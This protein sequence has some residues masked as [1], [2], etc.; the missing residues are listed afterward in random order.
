M[1]NRHGSGYDATFGIVIAIGMI[2]LFCILI[3]SFIVPILAFI[4]IIVLMCLLVVFVPK[5]KKNKQEKAEA[6]EINRRFNEFCARVDKF[7]EELKKEK[8]TSQE[9]HIVNN[10]IYNSKFL[11]QIRERGENYFYENKVGDVR[12]TENTYGAV[13][14]GKQNYNTSITLNSGIIESAS[15]DCKYFNDTNKYCKHIYALLCKMENKL[16]NPNVGYNVKT[17]IENIKNEI[18]SQSEELT[19]I[20]RKCSDF[21]G[22]KQTEYVIFEIN[23]YNIF[24]NYYAD[25]LE[26]LE[27]K[28]KRSKSIK[29]LI[30]L[31]SE[32]VKIASLLFN[33]EKLFMKKDFDGINNIKEYNQVIEDYRKKEAKNRTNNNSNE[34]D[35][36]DEFFDNE[37]DDFIASEPKDDFSLLGMLANSMDSSKP[38]NKKNGTFIGGSKYSEEEMDFYDLCEEERDAVR[39]GNYTPIDFNKDT[40]LTDDDY[41]FEDDDMNQ[42]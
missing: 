30:D 42:Q 26:K 27:N 8:V 29:D 13:V 9:K 11:P 24:V 25:V 31:H 38:K 10:A 37:E 15:C 7:T 35:D 6:E 41:Y 12:K 39:S 21:L 3:A 2:V 28:V 4:G 17:H 5:L 33:Y 23:K 36:F 1:S 22:K 14:N 34:D 20:I 19:E 32:L 40:E 18:I 16:E